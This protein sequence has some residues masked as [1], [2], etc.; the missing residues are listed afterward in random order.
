MFFPFIKLFSSAE[1][2]NECN[3]VPLN[4]NNLDR[5]DKSPL[6]VTNNILNQTATQPLKAI[7]K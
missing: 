3:T 7:R 1:I 5:S 2:Y 6:K 4:L